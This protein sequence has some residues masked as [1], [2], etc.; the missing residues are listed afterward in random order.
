MIVE[1]SKRKYWLILA[2]LCFMLYVFIASEPIPPETILESRWLSSLDSGLAFNLGG[3]PAHEGVIIPFH[4]GDRFGYVSDNGQFILNQNHKDG[5]LSFSPLSWSMYEPLPS[6]VEVYDPW[7]RRLMSINDPK[8][9][10]LLIDGRTF[11]IGSEQNSITSLDND[12][13]ERWTY[14]FPAPLTCID[15]ASGYILAGTMYGSLELLNESGSQVFSFEPGGSRLAVILGCAISRDGNRLAVIS[16]IDEQRFLLLE[17]SGDSFR[18]VYHEFL[19]SGYRR[20]LNIEFIDNDTKIVFEREGGIGIYNISSRSSVS[21][22]LEG[23]LTAL[24]SGD[25]RQFFLITAAA[26]NRKNL[27]GIRFPDIIFLNAPFRSENA[28]LARRNSNI[29]VA[30]DRGFISFELGKK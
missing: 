11:I 24:G 4:Y 7:N 29:Y 19:G 15:A 30:G 2:I 27:I 5:E 6:I 22:A 12:G 18:V 10:P 25:S 21:I 14:D 28:F 8:G 1:K 9:Y 13:N 17:H 26:G 20:A 16:G 23:E 3:S